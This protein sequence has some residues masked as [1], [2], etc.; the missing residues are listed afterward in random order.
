MTHQV[1]FELGR[2]CT[3]H[4]NIT[5]MRWGYRMGKL[6]KKAW[7]LAALLASFN[8][9]AAVNLIQNG[10][11]E[12]YPVTAGTAIHVYTGGC[13]PGTFGEVCVA[14]DTSYAWQ[15]IAGAPNEFLEIREN[16]AGTAQ[17]GLNFAELNPEQASG[18]QQTFSAAVGTGLLSWWDKG[19][20]WDD[21][22]TSGTN[23]NYSVFLNDVSIFTGD[24]FSFSTWRGQSFVVDLL[25]TNTLRFVSNQASGDIGAQIDHISVTQTTAV[26][27]PETYGMMMVGLAM[28]GFASRRRKV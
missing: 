17:S 24:T 9:N 22:G 7:A 19:R 8:V 14:Q 15:P 16:L 25:A 13:T 6:A 5:K 2:S 23:Y 28:L 1:Q 4:A 26:P 10:D 18:I 20:Q 12:S 21:A 11:F 3:K 27:E